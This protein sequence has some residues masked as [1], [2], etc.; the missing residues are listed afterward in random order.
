MVLSLMCCPDRERSKKMSKD[1]MNKLKRIGIHVLFVIYIA[2]LLRITVFRTGIGFHDL[3]KNGNINLTLFESYGPLLKTG[4][5][6]RIIYLFIGN[7]I[8]FV[9]LGF[10][11]ECMTKIE[12]VW[13]MVLIGLLFSLLIETLQYIF[14]TG[15]SEIDDLILNSFGT[16]IGVLCGKMLFMLRGKLEKG[17]E[18]SYKNS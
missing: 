2:V 18:G 6:W 11:L 13:L 1:K 10:Y 5:W 4:N 3:M 17:Y 9:P 7:I 16:W 8:W 12:K 15:I 14:G